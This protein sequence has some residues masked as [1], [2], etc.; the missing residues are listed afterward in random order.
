M[1]V[2]RQDKVEGLK[3]KCKELVLD[4]GTDEKPVWNLRRAPEGARD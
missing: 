2:M 3:A 4:L 1:E